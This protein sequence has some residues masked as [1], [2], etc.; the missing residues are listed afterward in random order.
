MRHRRHLLKVLLLSSALLPCSPGIAMKSDA[1]K[2]YHI[3]SD[4]ATFHRETSEAEFFGHV[5]SEHGTS[6]TWS[7]YAKGFGSKSGQIHKII[8]TGTP[9]KYVTITDDNHVPLT[10]TA[11][12]IID[13]PLSNTVYLQGNAVAHHGT[14]SIEGDKIWY[15]KIKGSIKSVATASKPTKT[16]FLTHGKR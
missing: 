5:Y 12:T 2:P 9:A 4:A 1:S 11:D 13:Y 10:A 3:T 14:E 16:V 8:L 7:H 15:D 6:K